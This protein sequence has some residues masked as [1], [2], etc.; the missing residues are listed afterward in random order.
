MNILITSAAGFIGTNLA[1]ALSQ[2][3]TNHLTLVDAKLEYFTCT[4]LH[5]RANVSFQQFDVKSDNFDALVSNQDLVFHLVST[6]NPTS[7]NNHIEA[8][9]DDN[10]AFFFCLGFFIIFKIR[11]CVRLFFVL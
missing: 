2:E 1:L 11:T 8:E 9:L 5:E 6:T 10:I 7:S 3:Q 4:L